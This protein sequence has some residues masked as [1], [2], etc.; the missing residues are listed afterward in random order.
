MP[1]LDD[2]A[3]AL[4]FGEHETDPYCLI[5]GKYHISPMARK[6]TSTINDY[7]AATQPALPTTS[8]QCSCTEE[9]GTVVIGYRICPL[10]HNNPPVPLQC[11][12]CGRLGTYG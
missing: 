9:A 3:E 8:G 11:A 10:C 1:H 4:S 2:M 12:R 7:H 5:D 6:C